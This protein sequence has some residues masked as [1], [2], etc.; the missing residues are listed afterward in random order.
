[1]QDAARELLLLGLLRRA[2]MSAYAV[3]RAI[4]NHSPLYRPLRFGNIYN[5]L[6]RFVEDGVLLRRQAKAAR[7]PSKTKTMLQISAKGEERF[8]ELL[9]ETFTDAQANDA[10]FEVA[11]VLLAQL[12]RAE[13]VSLFA[14]RRAELLS[15]ERRIQRMFGD[16]ES[17]S[18]GGFMAGTHSMHRVQSELDFVRNMLRLLRN[19]RWR[20]EWQ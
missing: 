19:P 2:P 1:M 15:R 5:S 16:I 18:P 12:P 10:G 20:S 13:S 17:R 6:E 7:G 4:R 11:L 14:E 9:R 3:D 8:F